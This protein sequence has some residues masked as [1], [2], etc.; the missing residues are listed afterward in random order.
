MRVYDRPED[1]WVGVPFPPVVDEETWE[2][3]QEAKKRRFT[4]SG[5]NTKLFYLLQHLVRCAECGFLMGCR[6]NRRQTVK[7]DGKSYR[8]EL[9]P[10]H[11]YYN[12]Y[13]MLNEGAK[14]REHPYIRAERL[15]GLVWGE[16]KK[17]LENP[18]LI[19][20][21]IEALNAQANGGGLAEEIARAER[22]LHKVQMEEGP[23][24]PA[25]RVG[26][27]HRE[28]AGSSTQVHHRKVG[29]SAEGAGRPPRQGVG[30][31]RE[32]DGDGARRRVGAAGRRQAGQPV[33]RGAQGGASG[34]FWTG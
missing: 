18:G 30:G 29:G 31:S 17:V 7:R 19:V 23:G 21:G 5:R 26:K 4:R 10:P 15:E 9:D 3:A 16:V 12:C 20:A 24:H 11:R 8:Y 6:A 34:S 33:G 1:E 28:A 32:A 14:C 27:D 13:G 22:D 25:L 2:L